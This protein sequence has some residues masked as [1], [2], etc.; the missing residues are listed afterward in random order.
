MDCCPVCRRWSRVVRRPRQD[1]LPVTWSLTSTAPPSK[2][3]SM[4]RSCHSSCPVERSSVSRRLRSAARPSRQGIVLDS[5]RQVERGPWSLVDVTDR[6]CRCSVDWA[7]ARRP[8][9]CLSAFSSAFQ[10]R[11]P[12]RRCLYVPCRPGRTHSQRQCRR[13]ATVHRRPVNRACPTPDPH[14]Y[15]DSRTTRS[16]EPGQ[17]HASTW[18]QEQGEAGG[19]WIVTFDVIS[20]VIATSSIVPRGPAVTPRSYVPRCHHSLSRRDVDVADGGTQSQSSGRWT[21]SAGG[22][23]IEPGAVVLAGDDL[24]SR[25]VEE[26]SERRR[27]HTHCFQTS[28]C[29]ARLTKGRHRSTPWHVTTSSRDSAPL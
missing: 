19:D 11:A 2:D 9:S 16:K 24:L 22:R 27:D 7:V 5:V 15:M 10:P 6:P 4:S 17:G 25:S 1:Y 26:L 3:S 20:D 23:N 21:R 14:R 18:T 8:S 12:R 28:I 29:L 13:T